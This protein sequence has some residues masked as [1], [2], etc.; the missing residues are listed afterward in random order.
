MATDASVSSPSD[1]SRSSVST[2]ADVTE[3]F[4]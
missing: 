1:V 3:S 2:T 4:E